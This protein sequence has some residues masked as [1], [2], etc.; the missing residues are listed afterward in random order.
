V[1]LPGLFFQHV[2]LDIGRTLILTNYVLTNDFCL[3]IGHP[4]QVLV[5]SLSLLGEL[6]KAASLSFFHLAV[7][8]SGLQT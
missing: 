3:L 4:H 7:S 8:L 5:R 6:S 2:Y 1:N